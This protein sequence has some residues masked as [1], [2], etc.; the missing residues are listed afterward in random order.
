MDIIRLG[1]EI[2][3]Q[4]EAV[5]IKVLID[6]ITRAN[7]RAI[8]EAIKM[9]DNVVSFDKII[10]FGR[11]IEETGLRARWEAKGRAEGEEHKALTIAQQMVNLGLPFETVV[12]A[13]QLDP[14]KIKT[15]F[16]S[17]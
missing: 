13:T 12:S 15:L 1:N 10:E 7:I 14:E 17:K 16:Y 4:E 11:K 6:V 8:E 3:R 2:A 5:R 9:S